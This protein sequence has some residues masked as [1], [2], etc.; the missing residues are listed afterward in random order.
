MRI[1]VVG[2]GATGGL[3]GGRLAAAGR[4]VTFLVRPGR[5]DV[6]RRDGLVIRAPDGVLSLTPALVMAGEIRHPYDVIL[7]TVKA[8]SL[9]A[10]MADMAPAVGPGTVILPVLN[11]MAHM[12]ALAARFGG[13]AVA[14]AVCKVAAALD[15]HGRIL[16]MT[17]LQDLAYGE[18]NG[19]VSE[20]MTRLDAILRGAGFEARLSEDIDREM[21][22]KWI[23]L[24]SLGAVTCLM[25]G[26]IGEVMAAPGGEAFIHALFDEAV[27]IVRAVGREP[28]APFLDR[29]RAQ[30]TT[31]GSSLT[32]SM[33]RDLSQGLPV[34]AGQILGD[35]LGR[36]TAAGIGAPL[37]S[38]AYA[39]LAVYQGRPEPSL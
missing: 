22:E 15:D 16:Q 36:G 25:R 33:Y 27:A 21:W 10:A 3:F 6:L 11:G 1:L 34:E 23:F 39:H 13:R 38:L 2:A 18:R 37:L 7:V 9:V 35:L 8:F 29:T 26:T 20:R 14:G 5:A 17:S 4:D 24:A 28:S 19:Q 12:E 32:S 31:P 30:L